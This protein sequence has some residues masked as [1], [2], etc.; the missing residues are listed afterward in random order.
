M[1]KLIGSVLTA[2]VV[3]A[4]V[5][6]AGGV[7]VGEPG[8]SKP[9]AAEPAASAKPF[10][11][12]SVHSMVSF[13]IGHLGVA[14]FYG[15]FAGPT[16]KFHL[17]FANPS[18]SV[19]EVSV[20]TESVLSGNSKRDEHLRSPD[21]FNSKQFPNMTFRATGFEKAGEQK[22]TVKGELTLLGVTKPIT[23]E[24]VKVGEGS[25]PQ[26]FKSGVEAKFEIKRSDFGM[27]KYLEGSMLSDDVQLM[28]A[29]EGARK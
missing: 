19:L 2:G 17:D 6:L 8:A 16:G 14:K 1:K 12:D 10:D 26:G 7:A 27:S 24:V 29:L 23:A 15:L 11:I 4:A 20:K 13:R 28:V 25:T 9:A 3:G 21:F 18:A 22:M 5:L